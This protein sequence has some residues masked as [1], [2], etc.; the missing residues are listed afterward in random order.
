[1]THQ[2]QADRRSPLTEQKFFIYLYT[3]DLREMRRFYGVLIGLKEVFFAPSQ[4]LAYDF[5]AIQLTLF[6]SKSP[7]T[8]I[9]EWARQPGWAGGRA[10]IVSW[11][12]QLAAPQ[13]R[14]AVARLRGAAVPCFH[15]KPQWVGYWSF[16]VRDPNGHT[17]ELSL[18]TTEEPEN[19]EWCDSERD[20]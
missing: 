5:G 12:L 16:P 14:A 9:A 13:F 1:L 15:D 11:S 6:N 4:A 8:P 18:P 17:V 20:F 7:L 10:N 3:E 2:Q 19:K